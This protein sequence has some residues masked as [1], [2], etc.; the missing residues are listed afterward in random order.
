MSDWLMAAGRIENLTDDEASWWLNRENASLAN[1]KENNGKRHLAFETVPQDE[2]IAVVQEFFK[3][4]RPHDCV[5]ITWACQSDSESSGGACLIA[6]TT[7]LWNR[8][9]KWADKQ[10]K[11]FRKQQK[12]LR[13]KNKK[14]K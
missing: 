10:E 12:K 11:K 5:T 1:V 8:P 2:E 9:G 7:S 4:F 6:A 13:R 3:L 14:A